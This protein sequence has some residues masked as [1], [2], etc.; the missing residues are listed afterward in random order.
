VGI[1][2]SLRRGSYN[3]AL[4][5]AA[6]QM[7]PADAE[8]VVESIREIP[9]YDGDVEATHG[10]PPPVADLKAAIAA[11]DGLLLATPEYNNG[12]PGVAK[13]AFDWLSRPPADIAR[14]FTA[15]PVA[16]IGATPGGFGT[17][18][19]QSAWLPVLKV[20]RVDLWT[21]GRVAVSHASKA[22]DGTGDLTDDAVRQ[23]LRAFLEAFVG[24]VRRHGRGTR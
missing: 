18:L 6:A 3:T 21:G 22:F 24:H 12:M 17:I 1:S 2:G 13:N 16:V 8:L 11:A 9:L 23:A 19:A 15:K 20:L 10:I 4:L 5:R 7:M 14:V